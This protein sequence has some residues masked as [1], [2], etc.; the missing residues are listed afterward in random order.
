MRTACRIG[1]LKD[2]SKYHLSAMKDY[3]LSKA[4]FDG[5]TAIILGSGMG[6]F[7]DRLNN[8]TNISYS[9]IPG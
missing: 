3:I 4:Q 5:D 6:A 1:T 8:L 2:V 7:A 9:D